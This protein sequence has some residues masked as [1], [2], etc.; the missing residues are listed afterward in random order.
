MDIIDEDGEQKF[1][2]HIVHFVRR[3]GLTEEVMVRH[4]TRF[5]YR[6]VSD[7][8]LGEIRERVYSE[9]E[10]PVL[11]PQVILG[12]K[13]PSIGSPVRTYAYPESSGTYVKGSG[14][15]QFTLREYLGTLEE[16]SE[17][18]RDSKLVT[19]PHYRTSIRVLGGASGGP[20]FDQDGHVFAVNSTGYDGTDVSY[21]ARM[22]DALDL[23]V[24]DV[25]LPPD[26]NPRVMTVRELIDAGQIGAVE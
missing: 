11:T 8:A 6:H 20:V 13:S 7:L 5:S 10:K 19:Y 17:K 14:S 12:I 18:A 22:K 2:V 21:M 26:P 25:V 23:Q 4:V 15:G 9:T 3:S 24:H 1:P 16:E